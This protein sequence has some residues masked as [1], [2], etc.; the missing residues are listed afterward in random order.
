MTMEFN[1]ILSNNAT[2]SFFTADSDSES[3]LLT[4][5]SNFQSASILTADSNEGSEC[6]DAFG[7]KDMFGTCDCSNINTES[8]TAFDSS[9]TAGSMAFGSGSETMGSVACGSAETAGSVACSSGGSDGGF[10]CGGFSSFC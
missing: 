10:S 2:N 8:F 1:F 7:G 5:G 3:T 9:E 4:A 6:I